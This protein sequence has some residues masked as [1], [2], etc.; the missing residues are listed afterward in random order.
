MLTR[1]GAGAVALPVNTSDS[2]SLDYMDPAWPPEHR[3][4]ELKSITEGGKPFQ[5]KSA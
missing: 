1:S 4:R 2:Q 5:Q 3:E